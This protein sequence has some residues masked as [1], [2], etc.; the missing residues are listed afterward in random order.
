MD[1]T[2]L[3]EL[4]GLAPMPDALVRLACAADFPSQL[5]MDALIAGRKNLPGLTGGKK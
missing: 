1:F 4:F 5:A 2:C 3:L